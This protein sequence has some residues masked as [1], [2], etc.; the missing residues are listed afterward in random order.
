MSG[1]GE[2]VS[3]SVSSST[4]ISS[5][6]SDAV[7]VC[8]APVGCATGAEAAAPASFAV[9]PTVPVSH[10]H[11]VAPLGCRPS[12][13]ARVEAAEAAG[14]LSRG[15]P[16]SGASVPADAEGTAGVPRQRQYRSTSPLNASSEDSF[17]TTLQPPP[18]STASASFPAGD[19]SSLADGSEITVLV[20]FLVDT[21]EA[22]RQGRRRQED[23]EYRAST[24]AASQGPR[25]PQRF[26]VSFFE[27]LFLKK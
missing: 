20:K 18:A 8:S 26:I 12:A 24:L 3:T 15:D 17:H 14:V 27:E 16:L 6:A 13:T 9:P 1:G 19:V 25:L 21:I 22:N 5:L 4:A 11:P 7:H 23:L 10:V 2:L